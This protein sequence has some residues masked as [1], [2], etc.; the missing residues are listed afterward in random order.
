MPNQGTSSE[1]HPGCLNKVKSILK[2]DKITS[3]YKKAAIVL[4]G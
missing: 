2:S 4:I 1:N 3:I